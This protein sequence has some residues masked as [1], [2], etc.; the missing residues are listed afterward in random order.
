MF[1]AISASQIYLRIGIIPS[2]FYLRFSV[3]L[4]S[5][6]LNYYIFVPKIFLKKKFFIYIITVFIFSLFFVF[7]LEVIIPK[8]INITLPDG[9]PK[10]LPRPLNKDFEKGF[11]FFKSFPMLVL[12]LLFFTLST[13]IKLGIEWYK[14]E[15]QRALIESQKANSELSFLKAQLNPHFLFNT[16]NSIYA[17][18]C[19][20]FNNRGVYSVVYKYAYGIKPVC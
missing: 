14:T 17:L 9:F 19:Q 3:F 8:P 4:I 15:K 11:F 6:Y 2:D 16:L 7:L 20:L 18:A 1:L 12:L 10:D 5:F 13:S